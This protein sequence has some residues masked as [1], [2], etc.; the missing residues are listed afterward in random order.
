MVSYQ[1]WKFISFICSCRID[2]EII[3][4]GEVVRH[5]KRQRER[6]G[7]Q[8]SRAVGKSKAVEKQT[9]RKKKQKRDEVDGNF[10]VEVE[11]DRNRRQCAVKV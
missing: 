6:A 10:V 5:R 2:K 4:N 7:K 11:P 3:I 9:S 8:S 1:K